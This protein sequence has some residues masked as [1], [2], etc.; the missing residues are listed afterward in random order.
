M[1]EE[2]KLNVW[3]ALNVTKTLRRLTDAEFAEVVKQMEDVNSEPH[4][5]LSLTTPWRYVGCCPNYTTEAAHA[6][7]VLEYCMEHLNRLTGRTDFQIVTLY[8]EG[9]VEPFCVVTDSTHDEDDGTH[10]KNCAA[11]GTFELAI[12]R[13]AKNLYASK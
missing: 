4:P 3:I 7:K 5:N 1:T 12:C 6:M 10:Q 13:F 9:S 2:Q 11:A 8:D